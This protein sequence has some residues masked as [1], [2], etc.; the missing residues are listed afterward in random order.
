MARKSRY[1]PWYRQ[2]RLTTAAYGVLIFPI[3]VVCKLWPKNPNVEVF[4]AFSGQQIGSSARFALDTSTAPFKYLITKN[5]TLAKPYE[6][7]LF[8][9]S[10]KG[11]WVQLRASKASYTHSIED[12]FAP[13]I[14]GATI[15]ALGYGV[16]VKQVGFSDTRIRWL[17][18]SPIRWSLIHLFP[19][20]LNFYCNQVISP[21]AFFDQ[22]KL[23][24]YGIAKPTILRPALRM[25]SSGK[26]ERRAVNRVLFAP[27]FRIKK[28]LLQT[29][30][31]SG[32]FQK[33][34]IDSIED[35]PIEIWI[36]PHYLHT[37]DAEGIALPKNVYWLNELEVHDDL[38]TYSGLITDYSAIFYEAAEIGI[39][40]TF[41]VADLEDYLKNETQLLPWF[42]DVLRERGNRSLA[43]A[44]T[45]ITSDRPEFMNLR[46]LWSKETSST[47]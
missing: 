29:L 37:E 7:T 24:M 45:K 20:L 11:I 14:M 38:G 8:A 35:K 18:L 39:P 21:Y 9:F 17:K 40:V 31:T 34:L 12:F 19:Y 41:L 15:V 26:E 32:L 6:G 42:K 13:T 28:T 36:H 5:R 44:I 23:E 1:T 4:G 10:L 22:T 33:E 30:E 47:R 43:E 25:K 3:Y 27:T 16:P 46:S 2:N